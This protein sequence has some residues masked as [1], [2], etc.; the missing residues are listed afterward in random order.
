MRPRVKSY[1]E[2]S[3]AT[4]SP[5]RI[6]IKFLRILPETC[7]STWCL[8]SSS[9]RNMAL[10]NGSMTVAMTSMASSLGFPESPLS[11]FFLSSNCF[12]IFSC[13]LLL[14][15]QSPVSTKPSPLPRWPGH[16]FRAR[17]D[18]RAIGRDRHGVL[19]V[20]RGTAIGSLR[21]PLIAH[22]HFRA[23]GI[24]HRLNRDDH[25]FLQTRAAP[26]LTVV[27]QIRLVVHFCADAVPD[28]FAHHRKTVL[29]DPGLH[30][31]ANIAESNSHCRIRVVAVHFHPKID[32][33]DVA[34]AQL[35]LGRRNA[36]NNLAVHRSAQ[37]AR[38]PAVALE[39]S[40]PRLARDL[41]LGNLLEV[42][43]S[44]AGLNGASQRGQNLVDDKPCAVHLLQLFRTS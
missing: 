20:R 11:L 33:D 38:V 23:P 5:A 12:A 37:R 44:H 19:E 7:A 32:R 2:S 4:L 24:D 25:A 41:F 3:T 9:T 17:E 27:R 16:F 6:R 40:V 42:H 22:P 13:H 10:G 14:P 15:G 1:G 8:F 26:F 28:E 18:P 30:R 35:A 39:R 36:M 34:F 21:S 43:R 29:L 31:V